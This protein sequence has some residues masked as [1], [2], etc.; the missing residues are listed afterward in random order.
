MPGFVTT[1]CSFHLMLS[2]SVLKE[3]EVV[4]LSILEKS[5]QKSLN[6][7]MDGFTH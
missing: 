4:M 1:C 7:M 2:C 3:N 6:D 5:M